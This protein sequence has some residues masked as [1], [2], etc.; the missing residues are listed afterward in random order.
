M[1]KTLSHNQAAKANTSSLA[2]IVF[3]FCDRVERLFVLWAQRLHF[4]LNP[5]GFCFAGLSTLLL[6]ALSKP[7]LAH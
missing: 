5:N 6:V 2:F 7:L 3:C 1:G 4:A